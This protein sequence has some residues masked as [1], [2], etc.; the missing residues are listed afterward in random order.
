MNDVGLSVDDIESGAL[1]SKDASVHQ[2][3]SINVSNGDGQEQDVQSSGDNDRTDDPKVSAAV[4]TSK[5]QNL[6]LY[7]DGENTQRLLVTDNEQS[8]PSKPEEKEEENRMGSN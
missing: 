7:N 4:S 3:S 5:D 1:L 6:H 8:K 2:R